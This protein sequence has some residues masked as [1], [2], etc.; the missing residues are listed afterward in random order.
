MTRTKTAGLAA[1]LSLVL[2]GAC[3][4]P[5]RPTEIYDPYEKTNRKIHAFN[6][7]LDHT[8]VR[9]TSQVYG[10]TLPKPVRRGISNFANARPIETRR[11]ISP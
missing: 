7:G 4:T 1:L 6:K 11:L 10:L 3:S 8:V 5:D 9:P 2:L